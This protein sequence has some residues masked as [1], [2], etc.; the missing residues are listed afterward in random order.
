[1]WLKMVTK[2]CERLLRGKKKGERIGTRGMKSCCG[3]DVECAESCFLL[4]VEL[5]GIG[6]F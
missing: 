3:D 4:L 1:M 6:R 2:V 5:K